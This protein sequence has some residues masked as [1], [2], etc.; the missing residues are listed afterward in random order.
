MTYSY[1]HMSFF[2]WDWYPLTN[3]R[4]ILKE[5]STHFI[6]KQIWLSKQVCILKSIG[7]HF[8]KFFFQNVVFMCSCAAQERTFSLNKMIFFNWNQSF[9]WKCTGARKNM[10]C[11]F[12]FDSR[13]SQITEKITHKRTDMLTYNPNF[14]FGAVYTNT[15]CIGLRYWNRKSIYSGKSWMRRKKNMI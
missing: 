9:D 15:G 10:D 14:H 7:R 6:Y 5:T 8:V 1:S 4:R 3:L 12:Y 13:L 11:W 2:I